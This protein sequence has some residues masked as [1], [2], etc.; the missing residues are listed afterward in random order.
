[1]LMGELEIPDFL[2]EFGR[3]ST[4]RNVRSMHQE[5][6]TILALT[7]VVVTIIDQNAAKATEKASS[8]QIREAVLIVRRKAPRACSIQFKNSHNGGAAKDQP[9]FNLNVTCI[10]SIIHLNYTLLNKNIRVVAAET[11]LH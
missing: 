8:N 11:Y 4:R 1:M 9:W 5:R 3:I 7:D 2:P 6:V 10:K